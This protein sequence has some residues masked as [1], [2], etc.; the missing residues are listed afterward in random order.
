[1]KLKI[2]I[3][4]IIISVFAPSVFAATPGFEVGIGSGYVFYGSKDIRE[5]N[6]SLG[7]TNQII[8]NF[9]A[10]VLYPLEDSIYISFGGDMTLDARWKGSN[11]INL[12]D[13]AGLLGFKIYPHIAGLVFS[14]DY[15]L[16]R[17]TDFIGID[18]QD[19]YAESTSWGNGF[20]IDA[21]YDFSVHTK[22]FAPALGLS[23]KNMPRGNYRDNI[24]AIYLRFGRK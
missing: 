9:D 22:G 17:R 4:S 7:D 1:M 20:R 15:A 2:A 24:L 8:L 16:G 19:A 5:R 10:K 12:L 21:A 13:Y 23:W 3:I 14:V 11:H 6:N 18:D